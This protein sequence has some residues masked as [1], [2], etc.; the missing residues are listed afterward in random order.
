MFE[1]KTLAIAA[2]VERIEA[3]VAQLRADLQR[4]DRKLDMH[5]EALRTEIRHL[6]PGDTRW[7]PAPTAG[8]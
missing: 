8:P 6:K 5:A 4:L 2:R 1:E 7:P 3:S